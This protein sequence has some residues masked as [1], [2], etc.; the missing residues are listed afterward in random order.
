MKNKTPLILGGVFLLLVVIFLLTSLHPKEISRGAEPLFKGK[1][2]V[3]DSIEVTRPKGDHIV[4]KKE[5]DTWNIVQPITEKAAPEVMQQIFE[6]LNAVMIDGTVTNDPSEKARFG[7]EDSTAT[8]LV[9]SGGGKPVLDILVGRYTPDLSHTYVRKFNKND[10]E[11]WRGIFA[12]SVN[13]EL[14][15]WRDKTIYSFN[16]DDI[17]GI[18][19]VSGKST[20]Q[21]TRSDSTWTFSDNG[22]TMPVDQAK[23]REFVNLIASLKCDAFAME[24]DIPRAASTTP[25]TR[26]SF[27]VRN[28]DT[29]TFDLWT[30]KNESDGKRTLLRKLD[31][32]V[33]YRFYEYRGDYLPINYDKLK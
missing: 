29:H 11:L 17:T 30:P 16:A 23:T 4:L 13:R 20:R 18:K 9:I 21:L 15:E 19:A 1:P 27:T 3:I 22:K 8:R 2:P 33:L 5:G 26:V 25:D 6:G 12:R 10:I 24:D 28:G 32:K 14:D 7:V 31:G